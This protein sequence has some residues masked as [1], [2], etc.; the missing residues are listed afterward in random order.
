MGKNGGAEVS[1]MYEAKVQNKKNATVIPAPR[2]SVKR[3]VFES[4]FHFFLRCFREL[5]G[6]N[7][8]K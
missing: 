6:R 4:V 3:M 7:P 5:K 2:K 1:K 8:S